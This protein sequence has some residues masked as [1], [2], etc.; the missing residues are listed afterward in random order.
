MLYRGGSDELSSNRVAGTKSPPTFLTPVYVRLD[1]DLWLPVLFVVSLR[2][3][4]GGNNLST[5]IGYYIC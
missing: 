2:L 1:S 4:A 5:R 3:F